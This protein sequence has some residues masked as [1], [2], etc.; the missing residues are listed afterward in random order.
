MRVWHK[1]RHSDTLHMHTQ[2][3]ET[4][5]VKVN[6]WATSKMVRRGEWADSTSAALALM[7]AP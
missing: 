3:L 6:A 7:S 5:A 4:A 2:R 1:D